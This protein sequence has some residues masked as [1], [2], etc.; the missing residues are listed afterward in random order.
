MDITVYE[1]NTLPHMD[2]YFK[3][4]EF[5]QNFELAAAMDTSQH[6]IFDTLMSCLQS[7]KQHKKDYLF[8]KPNSKSKIIKLNLDFFMK[9]YINSFELGS[10]KKADLVKAV[11]SLGS[12]RVLKETEEEVKSISV[13]PTVT[14]RIKSNVIEIEIN[15]NYGY[16]SLTPSNGNFTRLLH[17]KQVELRSV[18]ARILY[19]YF[20]S[21]LWKKHTYKKDFE[22]KQLQRILG[23]LDQKGKFVKGKSSYENIGQFKRRCL[24]TAIDAINKNTDLSV[25]VDDIK[26]GR[27]ILGFRF[28]AIKI[29]QDD[30]TDKADNQLDLFKP[31]K[32]QFKDNLSFIKYMKE[33]YK[34]RKVTNDIPGYYPKDNLIVNQNGYL[35]ME[36]S[37]NKRYNLD[38]YDKENDKKIAIK[39]WKWLYEN[40]DKVGFFKYITNFDIIKYNYIGKKVI[41]K[42][43]KFKIIDLKETDD[44][45]TVVIED[46]AKIKQAFELP[47]DAIDLEEYLEQIRIKNG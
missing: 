5:I 40:I 13:F 14:A 6:R 28:T 11:D 27:K 30:L 43:K 32:E 7:L 42:D 35:A 26:Q 8:L 20:L 10:I 37:E 36:N 34:N 17:S 39:L 9:R 2:S 33:N 24:D 47:K 4:N 44:I 41:I 15:E 38:R 23:I 12:I 21:N 1:Q 29:V 19:Q 25:K 46:V 18:Y 31:K 22:V 16:E 45:I 3:S